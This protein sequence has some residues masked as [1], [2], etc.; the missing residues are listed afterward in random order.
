MGTPKKLTV[1]EASAQSGY[2]PEHILRLIRQ[3]KIKAELIGLVYFIDPE[4]LRAYV[5]EMKS[6]NDGRFGPR[7]G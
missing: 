4:S 1:K 7:N 6:A 3:D 2:H 5:E